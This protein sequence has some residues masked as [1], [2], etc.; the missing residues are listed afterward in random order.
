MR[1]KLYM[2][3][4]LNLAYQAYLRREVP[5][6]ALIVY[7]G[8]IISWAYNEKELKQDAT[9]HAELLAIQRAVKYLGKWRLTGTT[10]YTTLE[11]CV[12]CAGA[13]INS[14][15]KRLVYAC[16]DSKAGAAGS[17]IDLVRH[18]GL[19]HQIEVQDG[20]LC[21]ESSRLLKAFFSNL[22]RDG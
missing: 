7:E 2:R 13:M 4:A 19:N 9:A 20:V 16:R 10:L 3:L 18:P 12:M 15:I 6:G 1:D 22:R 8:E 21:E 17:V 5:I 11:P 14:R